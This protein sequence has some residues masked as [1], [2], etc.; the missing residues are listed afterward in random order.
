MRIAVILLASLGSIALSG[1]GSEAEPPAEQIIVRE[2]GD[3]VDRIKPASE[4]GRDLVAAGEAAF[5]V[6]SACHVVAS[7]AAS[8]AG[9]NLHGIVG[10]EAGSL[11]DFS[12]SEAL[13]SSGIVWSETDL[14]A[15]ISDPTSKVPG[16][17]MQ[18]GAVSDAERRAAII[19]YL[20]SLSG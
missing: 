17:T 19:A 12:Y 20:A 6:C 14:D 4:A 3:P 9:P 15:Y 8:T 2:P 7:G 18:A 16:T 13:A 11:D 5:A 10:R 1:C